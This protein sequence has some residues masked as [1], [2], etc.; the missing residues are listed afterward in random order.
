MTKL[1]PAILSNPGNF[2]QTTWGVPSC[3]V[4]LAEN[5]L[6]LIPGDVLGSY[7]QG[8]QEGREEAR[9]WIASRS[10]EWFGDSGFLSYNS[11]TGKLELFSPK[12]TGSS[13]GFLSDLGKYAGIAAAA[14]DVG[15]DLY[16]Q[17]ED[18]LDCIG[19]FSDYLDGLNNE[20]PNPTV[21]ASPPAPGSTPPVY[22]SE[23]A[24]SAFERQFDETIAD[25]NKFTE[26]IQMIERELRLRR[27]DPSREPVINFSG[28]G[29]VEEAPDPIFRLTYGPPKSKSGQFLLSRD[30]IYY[31]SQDRDY[32]EGQVPKMA[33]IGMIPSPERWKLDHPANL[34]GKGQGFSLKQVNRYVGTL[35]DITKV[36]DS[37][38]MHRFYDVD[39]ML[40]SLI[41]RKN[42]EV[43][44]LNNERQAYIASGYDSDSAIVSNIYNQ[45]QSAVDEFDY[46]IA[47][48][49]KQIEVAV[50]APDFFGIDIPFQPGHIPIND[51]T[52]LSSL[53][54]PVELSKQRE[55]TF[56]HGEVQDIVLPLVPKY[57]RAK[58]SEW[59]VS[60]DAL[61][62]AE[63]GT[64]DHIKVFDV[65]TTPAPILRVTDGIVTDHLEAS[66]SFLIPSVEKTGRST[67][68]NVL[69]DNADGGYHDAQL[70]GNDVSSVFDL[71]VSI[72]RLNGVIRP[73]Y[74]IK[75]STSSIIFD[76][77]GSYVRLPDSPSMQNLMYNKY[78]CSFDT[79]L[80]MPN[81]GSSNNTAEKD[82][83]SV[84]NFSATD[85]SWTD[86]NYYKILIGNE[87]IGGSY[88][89]SD[90]TEMTD[91]F[92]TN[93]VRGMLIGFTRD[94]QI[95]ENSIVGRGS[96][97]DIGDT[98][99]ID[100]SATA[101][102]THFFI[103]PTQSANG[104][105]V[106]FIR[107]EP[108][109]PGDDPYRKMSVSISAT[110][111]KGYALSDAS[112]SFVHLSIS[113]N[114]SADEV[115]IFLN[116]EELQKGS[117]STLFG[118]DP[119]IP[120]NIP[121]FIS[122]KD[123]TYPS[124]NYNN[125][126][127]GPQLNTFFTP[128]IIGGGYTD[129]IDVVMNGTPDEGYGGFMATGHG[130]YSGLTGHIGSFKVYSKPLDITE[131]LKNYES[132][133]EYYEDIDL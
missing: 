74:F 120:A 129:G 105:D 37:Q 22:P 64:G 103:A 59:R 88:T 51:F 122:P 58:D 48:R 56:D 87:N 114:V 73:Q 94:P 69:N 92:G 77:L 125:I 12:N 20:S 83:V 119:K 97:F 109:N 80:Y 16:E 99:G 4:D 35:F 45:L 78:G 46:K 102:K 91:N 85:S 116:G 14:W 75:N 112:N 23:G 3:I 111:D 36:D 66:Y 8:L 100:T 79:W 54:L 93:T 21:Q 52:F 31:N 101:R 115:I 128:W 57:V 71:G 49:K 5:L 67:K 26:K 106:E 18:V 39:N 1:N 28:P 130:L 118:K 2:A 108:C 43:A 13:T 38:S 121:T 41:G 7:S 124:Y 19:E 63:I 34:G 9:S 33:D 76:K 53:N 89:E 11:A 61:E 6:S 47:K 62:V 123:S 25:I 40:K 65:S 98:L 50:K 30:G 42:S 10:K 133:K 107:N 117:Y 70:V 113:F 90:I 29:D 95:T 27:E 60:L 104:T 32:A 131:A 86:Y 132:H 72:P 24:R 17:V 127:V 96:D 44:K 81:L 55:L 84:P 82:L 68:F 110:T 15:E 126:A